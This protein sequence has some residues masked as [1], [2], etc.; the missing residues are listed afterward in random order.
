MLPGQRLEPTPA[1]RGGVLH[2]RVVR[3]GLADELRGTF[4]AV[5]ETPGG[6]GYRVPLDARSAEEIREGELVAFATRPQRSARPDD[7]TLEE[8]ARQTRGMVVLAAAPSPSPGRDRLRRRLRELAKIGLVA[9]EG[10]D[11]WRVPVDLVAQLDARD[12]RAPTYRIEVGRVPLPLAEQIRYRGPV[13][14]DTLSGRP[15][16]PYG[17]GAEVR[18]AFE[19]RDVEL[20]TLGLDPRDPERLDRLRDLEQRTL[21]AE[22]ACRTGAN[23]PSPTARAFPR[24]RGARGESIDGA[25]GHCERRFA[26][27]ARC[28]DAGAASLGQRVT[29]GREIERGVKGHEPDLGR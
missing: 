15:L 24:T 22:L 26:V 25:A 17:F 18:T 9:L 12:T 20:R 2:G 5:L 7:R 1:D 19:R 23:F 11:R 4:Y 14:L 13:W 27:R 6:A 21:G 29:L 28:A 16:A 3:K 8:T 10:P